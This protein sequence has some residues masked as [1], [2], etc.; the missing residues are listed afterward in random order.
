MRRPGQSTQ[1]TALL[2]KLGL[3]A[4]LSAFLEGL[5]H[6]VLFR[7]PNHQLVQHDCSR[8]RSNITADESIYNYISPSPRSGA[9]FQQNGPPG[10]KTPRLPAALLHRALSVVRCVGAKGED[11][12]IVAS[13]RSVTSA[14]ACLC[15]TR[16][17][18]GSILP[19]RDL[20]YF[21][22][23]ARG[24]CYI[25]RKD[26]HAG[27]LDKASVS[28]HG[29]LCTLLRYK[30]YGSTAKGGCLSSVDVS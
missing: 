7:S 5:A 29:H 19:S 27:G 14:Y 12:T 30:C 1:G 10:A 11:T 24:A 18:N 28:W 25:G 26:G 15:G 13:L 20:L 16:K 2:L 3:Q 23:R 4:Y 9:K 8:S 6:D 17:H 22:A 21:D